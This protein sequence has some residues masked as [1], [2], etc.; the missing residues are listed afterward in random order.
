MSWLV[1]EALPRNHVFI[2]L[3]MMRMVT[4]FLA[5]ILSLC[6]GLCSKTSTL[7]MTVSLGQEKATWTQLKISGAQ[8]E[9]RIDHKLG[10]QTTSDGSSGEPQNV[11]TNP[12]KL[13]SMLDGQ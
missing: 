4:A 6:Q 3:V 11:L 8:P 12:D 9:P 5:V 1:N 13:Y 7:T 10:T 2:F